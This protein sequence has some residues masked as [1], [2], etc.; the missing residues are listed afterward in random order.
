[1]GAE[2]LWIGLEDGLN[3]RTDRRIME[4]GSVEYEQFWIFRFG[5]KAGFNKRIDG[6]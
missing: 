5:R 3:Q 2:D 6:C 1:M 4:A